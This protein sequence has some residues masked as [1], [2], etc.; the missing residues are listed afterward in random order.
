MVEDGFGS[1]DLYYSSKR[2][3][4]PLLCAYEAAEAPIVVV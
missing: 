4:L 1:D 2:I 3:L